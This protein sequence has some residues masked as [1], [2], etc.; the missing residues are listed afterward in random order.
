MA[1]TYYYI[2]AKTRITLGPLVIDFVPKHPML[3]YSTNQVS[4]DG[5]RYHVQVRARS[6]TLGEVAFL[7]PEEALRIVTAC[8]HCNK[9]I[10]RMTVC[11]RCYATVY[12]GTACRDA[13]APAHEPDC[14]EPQADELS[15]HFEPPAPLPPPAAEP[16]ADTHVCNRRCRRRRARCRR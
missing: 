9:R 16:A 11:R 13:A 1:R 10:V 5:P 7:V 6:V 14:H 3:V 2:A 8:A 4:S 15:A 12:C